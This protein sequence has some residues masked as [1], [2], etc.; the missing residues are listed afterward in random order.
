MAFNHRKKK[1][2]RQKQRFSKHKSAKTHRRRRVR[3][4]RGGKRVWKV[5]VYGIRNKNWYWFNDGIFTFDDEI[6]ENA[7]E[8]RGNLFLPGLID[9]TLLFTQD[10][11]DKTCYHPHPSEKMIMMKTDIT[12]VSLDMFKHI[13]PT[14]APIAPPPIAP[15]P[16][17]PPPIAPP[18]IA[19]PPIAP[20]PIAMR[21]PHISSKPYLSEN[22]LQRFG[23]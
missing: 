21:A 11:E 3:I 22:R 7:S 16:I 14:S 19:P 12:C 5:I 13:I 23:K 8:I 17:A 18:P 2:I 10:K 1:T 6:S 20:P 9:G 4:M 15:P